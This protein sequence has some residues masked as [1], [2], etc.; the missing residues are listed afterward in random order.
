MSRVGVVLGGG[1]DPAFDRVAEGH[2]EHLAD[3]LHGRRGRAT[4]EQVVDRPSVLLAGGSRSV[5][6]GRQ[7]LL[8]EVVGEGELGRSDPLAADH[9][10]QGPLGFSLGLEAPALALPALPVAGS[11]SSSTIATQRSPRFL[12]WPPGPLIPRHDS[13]S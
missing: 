13:R 3:G 7:P 9:V 5:R 12:T 6:A 11:G 10:G 8:D 1:E 2:A 4:V